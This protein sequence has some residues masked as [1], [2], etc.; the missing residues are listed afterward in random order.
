MGNGGVKE[1]TEDLG[2]KANM[3]ALANNT[4]QIWVPSQTI[5][6]KYRC[7]TSLMNDV[8]K[9]PSECRPSVF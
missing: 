6:S 8:M 3:D 5:Q 9:N 1:N 4:K 2:I 7:R